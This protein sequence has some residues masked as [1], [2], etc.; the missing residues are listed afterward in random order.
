VLGCQWSLKEWVLRQGWSGRA[1]S[2]ETASG[3]LI[4]ALGVLRAFYGL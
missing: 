2:Q 3:I 4:G 1:L